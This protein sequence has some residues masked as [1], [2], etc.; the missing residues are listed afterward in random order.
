[1]DI[2]LK[3]AA[4]R[5]GFPSHDALAKHLKTRFPKV[6]RDI[7]PRSLGTKLGDLGRGKTSWWRQPDRA[8]ALEKVTQFD[9][10]E[11]VRAIDQHALGDWLFPEFPGLPPLDLANEAP[12]ELMAAVHVNARNS[13]QLDDWWSLALPVP[14]RAFPARRLPPG[15]T[16]L[17]VPA[18][19]G[20]SLLLA[21]L[22]AARVADVVAGD[23]LDDAIAAAGGRGPVVLAPQNPVDKE[24]FESL[25]LLDESRPVLV[26]STHACPYTDAA[27]GWPPKWEWLSARSGQRR[28]LELRT[29]ND[30]GAYSRS[31]LEVNEWRLARDWRST[32]IEWL[33]RRLQASGNSLFSQQGLHDW[34]LAFDAQAAWFATPSD[35]LALAA[36]CHD[37]GERR[38]PATTLRDAGAQL[39]RRIDDVDTRIQALLGRLVQLRWLDAAHGWNAPLPWDR[40]QALMDSAEVASSG[41][42]TRGKRVARLDLETMRADG[43]LVPDGD[44]WWGFAAPTQARLVLRDLLVKSIAEGDLAFWAA[45]LMGDPARQ[46]L[47]E[48]AMEVVATS[49]LGVGISRLHDLPCWAP[50]AVCASEALFVEIGKRLG[51]GQAC[52]PALRTV[53]D[54]V[55]ARSATDVR[56]SVLPV[57]RPRDV[58]GGVPLDWLLARWEWSLGAQRPPQLPEFDDAGFPGWLAPGD[59]GLARWFGTLPQRLLAAQEPMADEPAG[60]TEAFDAARRVARRVGDAAIEPHAERSSLAAML[61]L[62]AAA[63]GRVEAQPAWWDAACN[64][65]TVDTHLPAAIGARGLEQV[66]VRLLPTM[67]VTAC[68][69]ATVPSVRILLGP[70]WTWLFNGARPEPVL[71]SIDEVTLDRLFGMCRGLPPAWRDALAQRWNCAAARPHIATLLGALDDPAPLARAILREPLPDMDLIPALWQAAPEACLACVAD[72]DDLR[73]SL[74]LLLCPSDHSGTVTRLLAADDRVMPDRDDRV[75]WAIQRLQDGHGHDR[76]LQALLQRSAERV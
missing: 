13:G 75:A 68:K 2:R 1:M 57:S 27:R 7:E 58:E 71:E 14:S 36:L 18:G 19:C 55:L 53:L 59:A 26:I 74:L 30:G 64:L 37:A 34:L 17:T 11:L 8:A 39:L 50:T 49:A 35:V 72:E 69:L 44:G 21:R 61:A 4:R 32:L 29:G 63:D 67:L 33:D 76:T 9:A 23:T 73:G 46:S 60:F 54:H 66:A 28:R 47:V 40:W 65:D 3:E 62:E 43:L 15:L 38:L 6:F 12:P 42:S 52:T 31:S 41:S 70:V 51:T 20:R 48:A 45:P 5:A 16:W 56:G 10:S 22:R 25:S 24:M